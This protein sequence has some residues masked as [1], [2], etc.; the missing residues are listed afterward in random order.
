MATGYVKHDGGYDVDRFGEHQWSTAFFTSQR[1]T[2]CIDIWYGDH[3]SGNG[4][5]VGVAP[6]LIVAKSLMDDAA[7]EIYHPNFRSI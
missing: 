4:D 6:S 3:I 1:D 2:G 5:H 7:Q